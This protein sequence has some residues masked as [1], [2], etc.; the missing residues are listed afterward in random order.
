MNTMLSHQNEAG[1]PDV[2][3]LLQ[4]RLQ[5]GD[6]LLGPTHDKDV[7][8]GLRFA[9][10]MH[11]G[12]NHVVEGVPD[13]GQSCFL[14]V[15]VKDRN[16][17]MDMFALRRDGVGKIVPGGRPHPR[18]ASGMESLGNRFVHGGNEVIR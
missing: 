16:G 10:G 1:A 12:K 13:V 2:A 14:V 11:E 6:A 17:A 8:A 4:G 3:H 5:I 15:G 9:V 18:G 7:H